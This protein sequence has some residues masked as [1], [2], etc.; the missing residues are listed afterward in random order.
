[1][2]VHMGNECTYSNGLGEGNE[3]NMNMVEIIK[4]FQKDVQ[5]KKDDN[6]RLINPRSSGRT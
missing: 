2:D 3:E 6:E 1:M 5:S 4:K